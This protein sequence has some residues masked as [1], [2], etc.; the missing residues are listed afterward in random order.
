MISCALDVCC[1]NGE[2][3]AASCADPPSIVLTHCPT[4]AEPAQTHKPSPL[5]SLPIFLSFI[6]SCGLDGSSFAMASTS[7]DLSLGA[8]EIGV[9]L[10]SILYGM[11][12]ILGFI[13]ASASAKDTLWLKLL[14]SAVWYVISSYS[15]YPVRKLSIMSI[16]ETMHIVSTSSRVSG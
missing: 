16:L 9:L 13:Y 11:S 3:S 12:I 7:L 2:A 8:I 10:A 14:V 15:P 5:Y 1:M 6:S 4:V